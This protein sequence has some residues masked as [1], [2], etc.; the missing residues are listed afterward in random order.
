M[1]HLIEK[2][3][4][5]PLLYW[6]LFWHKLSGGHASVQ[7]TMETV[8]R[9]YKAN[10]NDIAHHHFMFVALVTAYENGFLKAAKR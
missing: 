8:S 6:V 10:N 7:N 4:A 9:H 1:T 5:F 2:A 3:C